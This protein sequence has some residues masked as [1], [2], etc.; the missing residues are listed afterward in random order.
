MSEFRYIENT[1]AA[2]LERSTLL[3]CDKC[4]V[5]FRGC[6]DVFQCPECGRDCD[7][8]RAFPVIEAGSNC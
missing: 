2:P 1:T 4:H 8:L 7:F 3:T 6:E 5:A